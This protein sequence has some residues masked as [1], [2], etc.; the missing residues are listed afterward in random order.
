VNSRS[1]PAALASFVRAAVANEFDAVG[2]FFRSVFLE[3][4]A[5][6]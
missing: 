4:Y 2:G 6:F 3:F 1:T 5:P